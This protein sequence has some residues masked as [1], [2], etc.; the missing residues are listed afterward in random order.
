M[1]INLVLVVYGVVKLLFQVGFDSASNNFDTLKHL[2][3]IDDKRRGETNNI[4]MSRL[5]KQTAVP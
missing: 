2:L 5:S 4:T 1:D 3:L